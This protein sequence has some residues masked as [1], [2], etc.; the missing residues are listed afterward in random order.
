MN[1]VTFGGGGVI[2]LD[3]GP[4]YGDEHIAED[5]TAPVDSNG[6][7]SYATPE[8]AGRVAMATLPLLFYFTPT[9][10]PAFLVVS[11]LSV[12]SNGE[13]VIELI[14]KEDMDIK[15]VGAQMLKTAASVGVLFLAV[16]LYPVAILASLSMDILEDTVDLAFYAI[17]EY[18]P[19]KLALSFVKLVTHTTALSAIILGGL[20][21]SI[22][23]SALSLGITLHKLHEE[24]YSDDPEK[25]RVIEGTGLA[26]LAALKI[27]SL[28][29]KISRLSA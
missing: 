5:P 20:K 17:K 10:Y 19:K 9:S 16:I 29:F 26:A 12:K 23:A 28:N 14:K 27:N 4:D 15:E 24:I 21:L 8:N 1:N 11:A 6:Y 22:T 3:Q 7:F 2:G 18:N 25:G 13:K